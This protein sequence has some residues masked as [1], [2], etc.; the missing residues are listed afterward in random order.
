MR[1][2]LTIGPVVMKESSVNVV[3]ASG[4]VGMNDKPLV[5]WRNISMR[6][7]L[8]SVSVRICC[9]EVGT[10]F[11]NQRALLQDM[12]N[13][14]VESYHVEHY[15]S[16]LM[17]CWILAYHMFLKIS[18]IWTQICATPFEMFRRLH[19][20]SNLST[21]L[22][23][24]IIRRFLTW[25]NLPFREGQRTWAVRIWNREHHRYAPFRESLLTYTQFNLLLCFSTKEW[26]GHM[27]LEIWVSCSSA[28]IPSFSRC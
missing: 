28:A 18:S 13:V 5:C 14:K 27:Y 6:G 11:V 15:Y 12:L 1:L 17:A 2:N 16:Q 7:R 9:K 22:L 4:Q 19:L 8:Y 20:W 21:R 24:I 23:L 25:S 26:L 3:I 10:T